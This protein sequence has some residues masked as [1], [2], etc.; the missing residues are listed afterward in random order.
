MNKRF[1]FFVVAFLVFVF[2]LEWNAP[3][4]FVWNPTFNHY[5]KQPFGCAVFD[6]LMKKS[7]PA[8][9]VVT[10]KTFPQL[11]REGYGKKP[12]AFLVMASSIGLTET[13]LQALD[14]LLKNGNKV[15]IATSYLNPDSLF[16]DL[17]VSMD[18]TGAF[19]PLQVQAALK[20]QSILYDTLGWTQQVPYQEKEY[21]V[22][23]AMTGSNVDI[24]GKVTCDTLLSGWVPKEYSD[25]T[26]G[27]WAPRV[28]SVKRGKGELFLSC[29][30]LLMTNYGILDTQTNGLIFRLMSQF[31]G[32]PIIRTEA[33]GPETEFETDTPLRFWLQNEP[34]RW[35][36]YL[37]LGG[38][39]LFC[40][41]YARRRQRV[42]PIVEEPAN[43][44]LEFVKLIGTLYHQKH[45][46][47]DLL[48]K[49]YSY[50]GETLRRMTMIDVEDVE[51]RKESIAQIALRTGM[52]EAEVRM[53]LD[54]VERYLQGND[55]LKDAALRKAI[56]GMDMIINKL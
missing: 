28:V 13:D 10:R 40:I 7:T 52:P 3:S 39:L 53:I 35:A 32:L 21:H 24:E 26:E 38:L 16:P 48:Q 18:G 47:R 12:H 20:H 56:D 6:S 55:E 49:K 33:Y 1:W 36:I 43:R 51:S 4:K 5:D 41:F 23:S 15:F 29:E 54:R 22:Y 34:L 14:K 2:L 8:G 37:T 45:I 42:I 44:S 25:S 27:Y 31:R 19:S 46:N 9:Y 30:P 17:N 11:E 50:F